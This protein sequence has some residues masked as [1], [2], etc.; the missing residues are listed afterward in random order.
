MLFAEYVDIVVCGI[1]LICFTAIAMMSKYTLPT[2]TKY[3]F[4]NN[5]NKN[6]AIGKVNQ[7]AKLCAGCTTDNEN[8]SSK[9]KFKEASASNAA[10]DAT[11][12]SA[13]AAQKFNLK[14]SV[15][16]DTKL[17]SSIGVSTENVKEDFN[18][19]SHPSPSKS[20]PR[21]S[22]AASYFAKTADGLASSKK[23]TQNGTLTPTKSTDALSCSSHLKSPL[24]TPKKA[25]PDLAKTPEKLLHA[26]IDKIHS[27][28]KI[29][30]LAS[31]TV[32]KIPNNI[33]RL[34]VKSIQVSIISL[35]H[36]S[37]HGI[38]YCF[39]S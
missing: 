39:I 28:S 25:M 17:P 22:I 31:P 32:A 4:K 29:P 2:N 24:K 14:K 10:G 13:I 9:L 23:H 27:T 30:A 21:S 18:A 19:K 34:R 26:P 36:I 15:K 12:N 3:K 16:S 20:R 33:V 6:Q 11:K 8:K 35:C 37:L 1:W 5:D 38:I 7:E